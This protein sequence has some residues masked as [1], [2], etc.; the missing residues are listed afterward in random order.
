MD[1]LTLFLLFVAATT[2]GGLTYILVWIVLAVR[3]VGIRQFAG[4][5]MELTRAVLFASLK[6][7][8]FRRHQ[9]KDKSENSG[10]DAI[11]SIIAYRFQEQ[12]QRQS[13]ERACALGSREEEAQFGQHYHF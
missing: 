13:E 12:A 11:D 6:F 9:K 3:R 8:S 2:M 5:V 4:A 10:N 7:F 1:S